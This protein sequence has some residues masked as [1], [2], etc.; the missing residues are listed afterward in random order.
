MG[1][2]FPHMDQS[3]LIVLD[4]VSATSMHTSLVDMLVSVSRV[5]VR[6]TGT[7]SIRPAWFTAG[8]RAAPVTRPVSYRRPRV[9]RT[10]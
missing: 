6:A 7:R 9:F 2:K 4:T 1:N 3:S 10:L 8:M 5:M